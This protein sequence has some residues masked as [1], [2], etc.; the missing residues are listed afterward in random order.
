MSSPEL[1]TFKVRIVVYHQTF[2]VEAE[3]EEQARIEAVENTIWDDYISE[4]VVELTEV[5]HEYVHTSQPCSQADTNTYS[6]S[7]Q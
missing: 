7:H 4:A 1:K 3:N 6:T 2:E 5:N